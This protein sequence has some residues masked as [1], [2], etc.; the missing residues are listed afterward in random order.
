MQSYGFEV[1]LFTQFIVLLQNFDFEGVVSLINCLSKI[2]NQNINIPGLSIYIYHSLKVLKLAVSLYW[3]F[4][5][6]AVQLWELYK[7]KTH[8]VE[9]EM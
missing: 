4:Y 7:H 6:A 8:Y 1:C 5:V 2:E 3:G 9:P